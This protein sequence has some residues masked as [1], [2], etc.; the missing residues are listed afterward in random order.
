[1]SIVGGM[2]IANMVGCAVGTALSKSRLGITVTER[3]K[4]L[5]RKSQK[6]HIFKYKGVWVEVREQS[7][8]PGDLIKLRR[9]LDKLNGN[10][11]I[12]LK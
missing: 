9:Y 2:A 7:I 4:E 11:G 1:M 3:A 12:R 8:Y 5:S 6:P 10:R